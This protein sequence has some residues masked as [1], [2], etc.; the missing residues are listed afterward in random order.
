MKRWE[1]IDGW[2]DQTSQRNTGLSVW[3]MRS[4]TIRQAIQNCRTKSKTTLTHLDVQNFGHKFHHF[5]LKK[6]SGLIWLC[7]L[8]DINLISPFAQELRLYLVWDSESE[9]HKESTLL[10]NSMKATDDDRKK[11][12]K[13]KSSSSSDDSEEARIQKMPDLMPS[14]Y[15]NKTNPRASSPA[16]GRERWGVKRLWE[17]EEEKGRW[18]TQGKER[19]EGEKGQ[20]EE[21]GP[22]RKEK[23]D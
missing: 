9:S 2:L 18:W 20:E 8:Y 1:P 10:S 11:S 12:R 4:S 16:I 21:Q 17:S 14:E 6:P 5:F 13:R 19:K 15:N 23:E 22:G 7:I 3:P